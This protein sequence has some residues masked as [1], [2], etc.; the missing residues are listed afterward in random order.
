MCS[1]GVRWG[2]GLS[3]K[4]SLSRV[5]I[6][7]FVRSVRVDRTDVSYTVCPSPRI[8][9]PLY[10]TINAYL[11]RIDKSSDMSFFFFKGCVS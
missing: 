11:L 8:R 7:K 3:S 6:L 10:D 5:H 4:L 9:I 2:H 1:A